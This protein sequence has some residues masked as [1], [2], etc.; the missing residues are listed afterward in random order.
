MDGYE[1]NATISPSPSCVDVAAVA[2]AV[3]AFEE[4]L[5]R[6]ASSRLERLDLSDGLTD[7]AAL[8]FVIA[9]A[10][11]A[12]PDPVRAARQCAPRAACKPTRFRSVACSPFSLPDALLPPGGGQPAQ[13]ERPLQQRRLHLRPSAFPP[14]AQ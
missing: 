5:E 11:R 2:D 7:S 3:E 12:A 1:R 14:R 6:Q 9:A 4:R 8:N 10:R 13:D